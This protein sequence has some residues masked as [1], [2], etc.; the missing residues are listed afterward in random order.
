MHGHFDNV[1]RVVQVVGDFHGGLVLHAQRPGLRMQAQAALAHVLALLHIPCGAS[2]ADGEV[3][4]RH[5]L[6]G[7][8]GCVDVK[9]KICARWLHGVRQFKLQLESDH[10]RLRQPES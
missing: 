8:A 1:H 5:H 4:I 6:V 10:A 3:F 7:G 2:L 9:E